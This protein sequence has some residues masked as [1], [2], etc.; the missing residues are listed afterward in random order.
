M[1]QDLSNIFET[2]SSTFSPRRT[3]K[4]KFTCNLCG[5]TNIKPVNPSAFKDGTIFARCA[6]CEVAHKIVD[7][8]NLFHDFKG[9]V[10]GSPSGL[11]VDDELINALP[12]LPPFYWENDGA[13]DDAGYHNN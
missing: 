1:E 10:F 3:A 9:P 11:V 13:R 8:L 6:K 2:T 4:L 5:A 12:S 7:N